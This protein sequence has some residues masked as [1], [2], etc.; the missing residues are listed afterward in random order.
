MLQILTQ[1]Y[2]T[3]AHIS[4]LLTSISTE[5]LLFTAVTLLRKG[6]YP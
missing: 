4:A 1:M 6:R 3:M 5:F 2:S